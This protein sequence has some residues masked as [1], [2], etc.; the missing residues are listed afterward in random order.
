MKKY[1]KK[2]NIGYIDL[3]DTLQYYP[4]KQTYYQYD[5]HLNPFGQNISAIY[6]YNRIKKSEKEKKHE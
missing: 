6:T 2:C 4:V 3:R 5:M 1:S